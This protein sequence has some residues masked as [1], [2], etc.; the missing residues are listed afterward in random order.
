M[1]LARLS[2]LTV[3]AALVAVRGAAAKGK[4][5]YED[6]L[7]AHGNGTVT[8][9]VRAPA[10]FKVL[11]RT[12]TQGRTRLYLL[13]PTAPKGGPLMDTKTYACEGAAGSFYCQAS[14]E[15][16]PKG[17]YS[18]RIRRDGTAPAHVELTVRW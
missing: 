13:G 1:T 16:L 9:T 12:P 3:L 5:S 7:P 10:S 15:A 6:T 4:L 11:L 18:F 2:F 14:Y 8:V 17:T